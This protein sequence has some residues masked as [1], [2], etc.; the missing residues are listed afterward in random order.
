[1]KEGLLH[2]GAILL[3][4]P[5]R[6][7]LSKNCIFA[8]GFLLIGCSASASTPTVMPNL[9]ATIRST[10]ASNAVTTVEATPLATVGEELMTAVPT[11][12]QNCT[13]II[14]GQP[15]E[16]IPER[17][18]LYVEIASGFITHTRWSVD[19]CLLFFRRGNEPWVFSWLT[20]TSKR[21][22]ELDPLHELDPFQMI[23]EAPSIATNLPGIVEL[24]SVS[25]S[26]NRALFFSADTP[27]PT[28]P[29]NPDGVY[30]KLWRN[31]VDAYIWEDGDFRFLGPV[32][33]CGAHE[34]IWTENENFIAMQ[35]IGLAAPYC[36]ESTGWL[37]DV[38]G[39]HTFALEAISPY[40]S[41]SYISGFSTN[42][43][44]LVFFSDAVDEKTAERLRTIHILMLNTMETVQ[45]STPDFSSP[46]DWIDNE[47]LL[48]LYK[49]RE[50]DP[51]NVG[52]FNLDTGKLTRLFTEADFNS[53]GFPRTWITL[54]PNRRWLAFV[55]WETTTDHKLWLM[56][57]AA[58]EEMQPP[59]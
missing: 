10:M 45:L 57:L 11:S 40:S 28:P 50:N 23:I 48:V 37:I 53:I 19:S 15:L 27:T 58:W 34:Y 9:T 55:V 44:K 16:T 3:K 18:E 21:L 25:P 32:E 29:A 38:A 13:P 42:Q 12:K 2:L 35:A 17:R 47:N 5:I 39:G 51:E 33:T 1:M 46:I 52:I 36:E 6:K 26:G 14:D 20:N 59:P 43:D 56:N 31:E 7:L 41:L 22:D 4:T 54:A 8:L 49:Q 30:E 24:V